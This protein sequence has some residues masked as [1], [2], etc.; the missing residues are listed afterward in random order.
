MVAMN[1]S[2]RLRPGFVVRLLD[3]GLA[4]F[5]L[6]FALPLLATFLPF[7]FLPAFVLRIPVPV[8][9]VVSR[10]VVGGGVLVSTLYNI[11]INSL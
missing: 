6:T 9:L 4:T 2:P 1:I 5:V 11:N 7:S 10:S 8:V 3:I